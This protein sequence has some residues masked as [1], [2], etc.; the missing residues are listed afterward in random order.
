MF[1][2]ANNEVEN[3][4]FV[5]K[6]SKPLSVSLLHYVIVESMCSIQRFIVR[7]LVVLCVERQ[8]DA[9]KTACALVP[10]AQVDL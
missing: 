7:W 3:T 5:W 10:G 1:L 8:V 9:A 4:V 6:I 2:K